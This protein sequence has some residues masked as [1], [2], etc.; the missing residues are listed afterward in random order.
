MSP[1]TIERYDGVC[2]MLSMSEGD[3]KPMR[4]VRLVALILLTAL[5]SGC[6]SLSFVPERVNE[7]RTLPPAQDDGLTAPV[8]D[9]AAEYTGRFTL[10]Y[11]GSDQQTLV[12]VSRTMR[13]T[14]EDLMAEK[15]TERL[16]DPPDTLPGVLPIAPTGT[17]LIWVEQSEGV[18][19]VNLSEDALS[20]TEQELTWM[21]SA[22]ANTLVGTDGIQYVN[23]LIG[24]KEESAL[25]LP[26]GALPKNDGNLTALWAQQQAD[27]ERFAQAG[28]RLDRDATLYFPSADGDFL[29]PEVRS[30]R[31]SDVGYALELV[32]QLAAGGKDSRVL[33]AD[34]ILTQDPSI[35]TLDDGRRVITLKLSGD[36]ETALSQIGVKPG[37]AY[38]ALA[39][40]LCRF[41]PEIDALR[42][43][44]GGEPLKS[45]QLG[46]RTL[47]PADGV[48]A[49]DDF[50]SLIGRVAQVFLTDQAT[51]R[52]RAV[53]RAMERGAALS[54]RVLVEQVLAGPMPH[55]SGVAAVAPS[56]IGK[57]DIEGVRIEEGVALVN[58]SG[59]FYRSCQQLDAEAERNLIYA[60]V[61]TLSGLNPVKRVRFFI[62]GQTVDA[63]V[64]TMSLRGALMPNPGIVVGG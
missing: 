51:G 40:T 21:R 42:I 60:L 38:G 57:A 58:L 2:D 53:S 5:L 15:I 63:L 17:K 46:E 26:S 37:L 6:A 7:S 30:V 31:F 33:P 35:D 13:L 45:V 36:F 14:G 9:S 44:L 28:G 32:K 23:V 61:N 18:A 3:V 19:T 12:A 34:S 50:D 56:G 64:T 43:T 8:G 54:P 1:G 4:F 55:E 39:L 24:G 25:A 29:L 10:N 11:V 22:I 27:Q 52:L 49:P 20:L 62:D 16:L 48:I 59:N 41:V 47:T